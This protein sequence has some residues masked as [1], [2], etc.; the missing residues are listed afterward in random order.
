MT[1]SFV[2]RVFRFAPSPNGCLHLGHAFSALMNHE[3]ALATGGTFLLRIED[4]D[5]ERCRPE[6][7]QAIY[8]DLRWLGLGWEEPVRRQSQHFADYADALRGLEQRGL[9]YPCFCSRSDVMHAVTDH[10][11]WPRDPDGSRLYPGTCRR[12]STQERR[13]RLAEGQPA[14]YRLD[15]EAALAEAGHEIGWRDYGDGV[16]GRDVVA[17]PFLWGDVVLARKEHR[18]EL[19]H[20]RRCRRCLARRDQCGARR[21]LVHGDEPASAPADPPR[22]SRPVLSPP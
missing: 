4:I 12:M 1:R 17:E 5:A 8:E 16:Q 14:A 20:R 2:R 19:S 6:F 10:L 18:G 15:M 3:M 21:G 9:L 7:E 13:R 11:E 22:S